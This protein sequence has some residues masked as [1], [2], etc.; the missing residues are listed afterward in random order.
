MNVEEMLQDAIDELELDMAAD[1][2]AAIVVEEGAKLALAVGEPG[3]HLA[4]RASR[5]IVALRL[6]LDATMKAKAADAR[7]VGII[8][9]I[10]V[11]AATGSLK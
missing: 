7:L 11:Q 1:K 9:S 6:A 2:A 4:V 3:F 10:L 5:D 8:Q